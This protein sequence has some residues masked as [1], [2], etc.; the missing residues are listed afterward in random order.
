MCIL[1]TRVHWEYL[2]NP[3]TV[4]PLLHYL[5]IDSHVGK[6]IVSVNVKK[7]KITKNITLA[8]DRGVDGVEV[9]TWGCP[10]LSHFLPSFNTR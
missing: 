6:G 8:G 2:G 3:F 4:L 5:S 10:E 7:E 9:N 1:A